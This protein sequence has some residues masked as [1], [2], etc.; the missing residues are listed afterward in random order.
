M[1]KVGLAEGVETKLAPVNQCDIIETETVP[2]TRSSFLSKIHRFVKGLVIP[3]DPPP[4]KES[5]DNADYIP[6]MTA[7]WF[8]L[9]TFGWMN[10]LMT[11]GYARPL[12]A[13]DLWKLQE[14]RSSEVIANAI[15]DSFEARRR[16]SD[17]FN[18]RLANGEIKPPLRLRL[19][20]ALRGDGEERL[21]KWVEKDGKKQPSLTLAI[22][23]SIKWWF[24]SG[25]ILMVAGD[26]A[27]VTSP[28]I[29][30]SLIEFATDS[31]VAHRE[32]LLAPGVGRGIAL[33]ITL[34]ILQLFSSLCVNH[35]F[36][37]TTS[38][39]VLIRGGLITAI[40][41]RSLRLTTG[42]R[43]R[44]SNGRLINHIS[45]DV[46]R[47]DFCCGF[48]HM[49]WTA[50]IQLG[51]CLGLLISNL[52]PSALAGFAVFIV[53]APIQGKI[54]Q[55][56]FQIRQKTMEWTDKR[57]KLLQELLGGIKLIKFFA[58]EVPFLKRVAGYR[59]H[60]LSYVRTLLL[61]R[62][63]NI[64]MFIS[65]P[66]LASVVAFLVYAGSGHQLTPAVIFSSL[67]WFQLLRL[68]LM[69][70]PLSLSTIAD[71]RNAIGRLQECF[72]AELI[73]ETLVQDPNLK[74]AVEINDASF[75]WDGPPPD[76]NEG[77]EDEG[78]KESHSDPYPK[79]VPE[80][81][82]KEVK[83]EVLFKLKNIDLRVPRGQ[84]VA[85]VGAVGSGKTSLLQGLIGDMRRTEGSVRVGGSVAYC[86]QSAWI[87]NATIRDN[88]CFG[89]P[90]EA[91]RYWKA[92]HDA[93]LEPDLDVLPNGDMTEVGE[94]GISLSGGQKQRVN[95]CRAIYSRSDILILDDPLSALDAHVG[96][97]VFNNV[98]LDSSSGATRILV[99]HALHFLPKVDH[100]YF[101]VDG[102]VTEH[103]PF[104][105]MMA[106]RSD[107]A[108]T[109]DEFVTKDQTESKGEKVVD[110]EDVDAD[111]DIKKRR[112]AMRGAQLM[113]AEE[114]N[115]GMVSFQVYKHYI[116][117]GNGVVLI[118]VMLVT[119]VLVEASVVLSSYWLVWW[120]ERQWQRPQGFYM[121]IYAALNVGQALA[122]FLN[123][124]TVAFIVYSASRRMHDNAI[125]RV[126]LS[127]MSFFETTPVGRI[128]N[129]FSK[130]I[131]TID[132]VLVDSL[133]M[134]INAISSI[135]GAIVLISI[136][137]PWFLIVVAVVSVLFA[138]ASAFYRASARE[139]KRLDAILRSSLYSHFSE[140]LSG[141]ATIRAYGEEDR[142]VKENRDQVNIENRAYW[143]TVTNQRWLGIRL[144]FLGTLL[145]LVVAMLTV[146]TRFSI[147]PAQTGV[148]LSYILTIQQTF[149]WMIRQLAEVENDMNS[150]ERILYY[151]RDL[152]QEPPHEIPDQKPP[153]PWPS[154]GKLEIHEAVLKYRPELPLILKGLSMSI[155]GGEKIGI[156]GRTGAGKSSIMV[157]LFRMVELVSGSISIDGVDI[158]KLGLNDVRK[159]ISII[160][161]DS[162]LYPFGQHDDARLWDALRRSYLVVET[163]RI[164]TVRPELEGEEERLG[165]GVTT[166]NAPRFTLD[167]T[168]EEEGSNLSVGQRSLVSLA[169]ALVKDSKILILDEATAS[170]DYETD[171]KIQETIANEFRD[172]TILCIA[173]RLRTIIS[174]DR[175]CVLDDGKIAEFDVPE[176]LY[177]RDGIFRGM[178]ERSSITLEDIRGARQELEADDSVAS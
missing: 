105:E 5:I 53:L 4:P 21:R 68:P 167:S 75:T 89:R 37:R 99:T 9:L 64:A 109:F 61:V 85:I 49:S 172:R 31:Y 112:A 82:P 177:A 136:L 162:T 130:D 78:K 25:G 121:G 63:A 81:E 95:I 175:I 101:I 128:M 158:S 165:T 88:I 60:E 155:E 134:F 43:A 62:A 38:S 33:A 30:K 107:F 171:R 6:E 66:A 100:I 69:M 14:H 36:Y 115:T 108:R 154:N 18:T 146:G 55:S 90:F 54:M 58:W 16:K 129:R 123:G 34:V 72:T 91:E 71:A 117:S 98:L 13:S 20:S 74:Y 17:E 120:Q 93:C 116:Q 103:G 142:F 73:S 149:T 148:T 97:S 133:R 2:V 65:T 150:V 80:S 86:S 44:L 164:S 161:Q 40:Y 7:G 145:T 178:C 67:T 52:G 126:M 102:R 32:G 3:L 12:E 79:P 1:D 47:I 76:L 170:V 77:E 22:N 39:G 144:D 27:Q 176:V 57:A 156:V 19:M 110:I 8:S 70:L 104:D 24:W 124:I 113:Q 137:L 147:S 166:P 131:D 127:P 173:H 42:S 46:S 132:N 29:L 135:I 111:E 23:D 153:A 122:T 92:V 83:E 28:L 114:R 51:I 159:A 106:N 152:E 41:S 140:T 151:A 138:M 87:Q 48:F 50:P 10:S 157:A 35:A 118:P 56:F 15:L 169:R 26:T 119:L 96:E 163:N 160:P 125:T 143:M 139:I 59:K 174:Y 94:R 84:L 141:I 168:I 11:L 45:T